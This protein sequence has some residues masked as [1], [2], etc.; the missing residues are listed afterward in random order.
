MKTQWN[1]DDE[2]ELLHGIFTSR[3]NYFVVVFSLIMNA[4]VFQD[5]RLFKFITLISGFIILSLMW[6]LLYRVGCKYVLALNYLLKNKKHPA[7]KLKQKNQ[8]NEFNIHL[9]MY[10]VIPGICLLSIIIF[11]TMTYLKF[12]ETDTQQA[13]IILNI[14]PET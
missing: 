2:R 3:F 9:L 7:F 1:M 5:D 13:N 11:S 14:H 4:A 10:G 12:D 8:D 6:V